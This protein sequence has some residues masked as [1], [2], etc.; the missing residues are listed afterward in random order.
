MDA[1]RRQIGPRPGQLQAP[2]DLRLFPRPADPQVGVEIPAALLDES[3]EER[4]KKPLLPDLPGQRCLERP[5]A[6]E[7]GGKARRDRQLETPPG[8]SVLRQRQGSGAANRLSPPFPGNGSGAQTG[9]H[10]PFGPQPADFP[11][12]KGGVALQ[13]EPLF[14]KQAPRRPAGETPVQV[15]GTGQPGTEERQVDAGPFQVHFPLAGDG[16]SRG[17]CA[18]RSAPSGFPL[19]PGRG[20]CSRACRVRFRQG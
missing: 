10:L 4:G 5:L 1:R 18:R 9:V 20:R 14:R 7:G 17:L 8:L 3:R 16:Q 15:D 12:G 19:R 11:P 2:L 6:V 13:R